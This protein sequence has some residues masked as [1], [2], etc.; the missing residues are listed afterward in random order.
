MK[1]SLSIL[2]KTRR[3]AAK[4]TQKRLAS[5]MGYSTAQFISNIEAGRAKLPRTKLKRLSKS[6][7]IDRKTIYVHALADEIETLKRH[8]NI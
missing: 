8:L 6:L 3:E 5:L 4:M 2:M 1:T 7:M